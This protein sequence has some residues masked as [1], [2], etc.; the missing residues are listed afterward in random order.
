MI[1]D[2]GATI[3]DHSA[4][5]GADGA[6]VGGRGAVWGRF[7]LKVGGTFSILLRSPRLPAQ[8]RRSGSTLPFSFPKRLLRIRFGGAEAAHPQPPTNKTTTT[9]PPKNKQKKKPHP[10]KIIKT[11]QK[12]PNPNHNSSSSRL[13]FLVAF[14]VYGTTVHCEQRSTPGRWPHRP[15]GAGGSVLSL[16]DPGRGS[17]GAGSP[18]CPT[19]S[20]RAERRLQRLCRDGRA[21]LPAV[22]SVKK[23]RKEKRANSEGV[24]LA[25]MICSGPPVLRGSGAPCRAGNAG[26]AAGDA[27][28]Q[29]GAGGCRSPPPGAAALSAGVVLPHGGGGPGCAPHLLLHRTAAQLR[30]SQPRAA[31]GS[32]A[33]RRRA[34]LAVPPFAPRRR[35][36]PEVEEGVPGLRLPPRGFCRARRRRAALSS[37]GWRSAA[38][39]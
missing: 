30:C 24:D 22:G 15:C 13:S 35:T 10:L 18:Q 38:H 7:L 8:R 34:P 37:Q 20:W 17:G 4:T 16:E 28:L 32:E 25:V 14:S 29:C 1:G 9:N 6:M 11:K 19:S 27:G 2:R 21:L 39:E 33:G 12:K 5:M 26:S 36:A 31:D 3:R 23:G